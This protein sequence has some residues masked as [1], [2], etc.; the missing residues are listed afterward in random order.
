MV[1]CTICPKE[2]KNQGGLN[3]HMRSHRVLPKI[4]DVLA[5]V[6]SRAVPLDSPILSKPP[7]GPEQ[8]TFYSPIRPYLNIVV[9]PEM[10]GTKQIPSSNGGTIDIIDIVPGITVEFDAGK[11][12]T[13]DPVIIDYL[14]NKYANQRFPIMSSRQMRAMVER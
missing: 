11:Y 6:E 10:K 2:F 14:E 5:A 12:F 13:S 8:V 9:R 4:E 7:T 3:L 1:N